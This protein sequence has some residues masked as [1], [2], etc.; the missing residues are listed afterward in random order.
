MRGLPYA[1]SSGYA[2]GMSDLTPEEQ[3]PIEGSLPASAP[4]APAKPRK[5]LVTSLNV[6]KG[7]VK[8]GHPSIPA[9]NHAIRRMGEETGAYTAVFDND[10]ARFHP[11]RIREFDAVCFN[12]T[13]GMITEDPDLQQGILGFVRG[14]GGWV[15]IHAATTTFCA[16]PQFDLFPEFGAMMGGFESGGH[17]WGPDETIHFVPEE[18]D[19]PLNRPFGG[20]PFSFEEE[21]FQFGPHYSRDHQ[22][23]LLKIDTDRMDT[24]PDRRMLPER[25]EDLDFAV[26]WIRSEGKGRVFYCALGHKAEIFQR[27]PILEHYLAGIQYAL[28]DLKCDDSPSA[29]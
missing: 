3:K 15:G 10:P 2:S 5:L 7:E 28:G 16:W 18:A 27:K 29:G 1:E 8:R 12:N 6:R 11:D 22:R 21:V 17:P 9:A 19:H 4:A 20:Q 25:R 14:G 26:T 24:G 13:S 23:V